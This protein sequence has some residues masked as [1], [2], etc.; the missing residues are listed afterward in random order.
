MS[1]WPPTLPVPRLTRYRAWLAAEQGL[2]FA[3]HESLWRWST[4]ELDAFWG[5][6]WRWFEIESPTPHTAV[7]AEARMPGAVWFPGAQVNFAR[8]VLRHGP[9]AHAAGHPAVVWQA[10]RM[11]APEALPWPELQ[12]R[13]ACFAMRLRAAGV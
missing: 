11:P 13:V 2:H 8:Q 5:S 10:E 9:A 3:D 7:L 4:T 12:R 6:L 1:A